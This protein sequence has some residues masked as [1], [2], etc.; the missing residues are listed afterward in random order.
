MQKISSGITKIIYILGVIASLNFT[1]FMSLEAATIKFKV[2][3]TNPSKLKRQP[4]PIKVYLPGEVKT[5]DILG[6]GGLQLEYDA[7][8]SLYYVYKDDLIL[9][10]KQIRVFEVEVEDVWNIPG[11]ELKT[12]QSKV[13][14]LLEAFKDTDYYEQMQ[15]IA[16]EYGVLVAEVTKSQKD[17][18]LSRSQHI[19]VFRTNT[20]VFTHLKDKI[21]EME[22]ILQNIRGPLTPEQLAK[23]KFKT[24]S[25]TKT[26]TWIAIFVI[27]IFL[28]LVST[29]VFFTW[30][31][32]GK[33][34][35]IILSEAKESSFTDFGEKK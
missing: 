8:K 3:A 6:L 16:G 5:T 9:D 31:R 29:I 26:A 12:T 33:A 2:V 35:E 34:T 4:V 28:G 17:D 20:K 32:Q 11:L 21:F 7:E 27:I 18:S 19:G 22:R 10:P 15:V 13:D 23:T 25:P 24:E 1:G 14:Y 30:D